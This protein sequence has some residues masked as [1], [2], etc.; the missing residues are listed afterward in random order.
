MEKAMFQINVQVAGHRFP[1]NIRRDEEILYRD[2]A[3]TLKE[4]IE[5]YQQRHPNLPYET[6]L[7]MSAY[8]FAVEREKNKYSEDID[9]IVKKLQDFDKVLDH[10][11]TK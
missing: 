9:P 4:A 11:L 8:H 1:L 6:I 5:L 10:A 7:V 3:K 2:A